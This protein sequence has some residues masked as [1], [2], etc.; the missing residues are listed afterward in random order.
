MYFKADLLTFLIKIWCIYIGERDE[1]QDEC[2]PS[3]DLN[4]QSRRLKLSNT[5]EFIK[6]LP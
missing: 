5:K 6:H 2:M 4:Y 1:M 3:R